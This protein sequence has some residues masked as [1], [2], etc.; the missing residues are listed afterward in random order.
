MAGPEDEVKYYQQLIG[1][2]VDMD[3]LL[4]SYLP[5]DE[6]VVVR[7]QQKEKPVGYFNAPSAPEGTVY[8]AQMG[9]FV[10]PEVMVARNNIRA[11]QANIATNR[12]VYGNAPQ[13]VS[14]TMGNP[15]GPF[16]YLGDMNPSVNPSVLAD[17]PISDVVY[18]TATDTS[19]GTLLSALTGGA[20]GHGAAGNIREFVSM[21]RAPAIKE[22]IKTSTPY[23]APTRQQRIN[24]LQREVDAGGP[25][26]AYS[27]A[28]L[29]GMKRGP[30]E[31]LGYDRNPGSPVYDALE[32]KEREALGERFKVAPDGRIE[33]QPAVH[34]R[35]LPKEDFYQVPR[36]APAQRIPSQPYDVYTTEN[37]AFMPEWLQGRTDITS[38]DT[39]G[40]GGNL[41][42][43][44]LF[45]E[46][47]ASL[48]RFMQYKVLPVDAPERSYA[49]VPG[50]DLQSR[51]RQHPMYDFFG[52]YPNPPQGVTRSEFEFERPKIG[53]EIDVT[54]GARGALAGTGGDILYQ[55]SRESTSV[56]AGYVRDQ[57]AKMQGGNYIPDLGDLPDSAKPA[58]YAE[59]ISLLKYGLPEGYFGSERHIRE[60]AMSKRAGAPLT[61]EVKVAR[62]MMKL[63][64]Q[65]QNQGTVQ[66]VRP[67]L[68][69]SFL[70]SG[71]SLVEAQA[72]AA[73]S[74]L[75]GV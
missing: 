29:Q 20:L 46:T 35:L 27:W 25:Y 30:V 74:A 70:D 71:L 47:P 75:L 52:K 73:V 19:V 22:N 33:Y 40:R 53:Q 58:A 6:T 55:A 56:P 42:H 26:A 61:N 14:T 5:S 68:V 63:T 54:S 67:D 1:N 44:K 23:A 2:N 13:Y 51:S 57:V 17:R 41:R 10:P 28:Q 43:Y 66:S 8:D 11:Q 59:I 38:Y 64:T 31:A 69:Q 65:L 12:A 36:E 62:D 50:T 34:P 24:Q 48:Q 3:R 32:Y 60:E 16:S 45:D 49:P 39:E 4:R 9:D 18:D 7:A 37:P 72:A 15:K 21:S